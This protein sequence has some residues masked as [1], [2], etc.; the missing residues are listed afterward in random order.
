MN[1]LI[2]LVLAGAACLAAAGSSV[3][4]GSPE[5]DYVAARDAAI[6][7]FEALGDGRRWDD[8]TSREHDAALADLE[9]RMRA[10]VGPVAIRD[11]SYGAL[12][13]NTLLSTDQNFGA[14]DGL[15]FRSVDDKSSVI[16]T[17][18]SIFTKWLRV[19][20]HWLSDGFA[21]LPQDPAEAFKVDSFYVQAIQTDAAVMA[22]GTI[23]LARPAGMKLVQAILAARSQ[24][25]TP[26][27]PEELFV[28]AIRDGRV[29]IANAPLKRKFGPV[30]VCDEVRRKQDKAA[31]RA[32]A[33]YDAAGSPDKAAFDRVTAMRDRAETLFLSCFA[34]EA[35][36][37]A[38][39]PAAVEQA[40]ALLERLPPR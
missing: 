29:F 25:E 28:A 27:T 2:R 31:E 30:A 3:A 36:R 14:L 40:Q 39:F 38:A 1:T 19:H 15:V 16:V 8:V 24:S 6:A 21:A 18:E 11:A 23:P 7:R 26:P 37:Q 5:E 32:Q 12:N 33:A 9:T 22:F 20:E 4:A 35:V 13:V 17:T 10:V 34:R